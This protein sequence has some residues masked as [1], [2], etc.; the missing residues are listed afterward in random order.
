MLAVSMP[1]DEISSTRS[2]SRSNDGAFFS[3]DQCAAHSSGNATDNCTLGFAMVVPIR[4]T[5]RET[6]R[7][8]S[9]DHKHDDQQHR[10]DVLVSN[11]LYH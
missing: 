7:S 8:G 11:S 1:L 10:N 2:C 6:I 5:V 3:A 9:Q 4:T